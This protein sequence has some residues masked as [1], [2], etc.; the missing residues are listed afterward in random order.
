MPKIV[1]HT[2]DTPKL[3]FSINN[4]K[5]VELQLQIFLSSCNFYLTFYTN[6]HD[7][8]LTTKASQK[9][10]GTSSLQPRPSALRFQMFGRLKDELRSRFFS[11]DQEV[12]D[13]VHEWISSLP[14]LFF[15]AGINK[16]VHRWTK[17]VEC[18]G[19]YVEK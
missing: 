14:R 1:Y 11:T 18:Q 12:K 16:L 6:T 19:D 3:N 8:A 2:W 17:C 13:T 10:S 5:T 15:S 4:N 9:L 7:T